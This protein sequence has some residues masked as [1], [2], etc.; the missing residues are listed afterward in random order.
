MILSGLPQGK[1]KLKKKT[2]VRKKGDYK[3]KSANL[4]KF[5]KKSDF[6]SS[7]ILNSSFSKAFK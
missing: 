5:K 2:K 1:E 3:K 7:N 6:I 4:T